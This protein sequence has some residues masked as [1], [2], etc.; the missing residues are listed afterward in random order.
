ML[1]LLPRTHQTTAPCQ[2][3]NKQPHLP[4]L[5]PSPFFVV[6]CSRLP[7][8]VF[9]LQLNSPAQLSRPPVLL[10]G[11]ESYF[12]SYLCASY[13]ASFLCLAWRPHLFGFLVMDPSPNSNIVHKICP[14]PAPVVPP[15]S[16]DPRCPHPRCPVCAIL[17]ALPCLCYPS[18]RSS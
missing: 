9:L 6:S 1:P 11:L 18:C 4:Q 13:F 12:L 15:I 10:A 2:N 16:P 14:P 5:I 7:V 17:L 3:K 8:P